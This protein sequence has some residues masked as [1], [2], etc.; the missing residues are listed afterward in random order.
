M[1]I[2]SAPAGMPHLA[3]TMADHTALSGQ[4]ARAFGN[5][6]FE[7]PTP[8]EPT[9]YAIA[10]HDAGWIDFDREPVT[11]PQT[12]LPYSV[13]ATPAH[14]ILPTSHASPDY[15]QRHHP[16]SG[17]L[18]SMHTCGIYNG[19][20]GITASGRLD[21]IAPA[22]RPRVEVLMA[23]EEDRQAA[24]KA[25]LA[26]SAL[27]APWVEETRVFQNYKLMQ[28]CDLLA[29]YFNGTHPSERGEKAFTSVPVSRETD[30]TVT[31]RRIADDA[32]AAAPF[33]FAASGSEFA[34]AGRLIR[35]GQQE[36]AGS[37]AA[38]LTSAPIV[39]QRFT[40][41]AG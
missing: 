39:W 34:F 22:D 6:D 12:G 7:A 27:T 33:P 41:V 15:N 17:L 14:L 25:E 37:W 21:R 13:F 20:Y 40:I 26:A 2:Q 36:R 28:F 35:P 8:H 32:Y 11:D 16:Y 31:V 29:I 30:E 9:I 38:V 1:F 4:F 19:R 24:L 5:A 18:S 10:N 3:V 23:A